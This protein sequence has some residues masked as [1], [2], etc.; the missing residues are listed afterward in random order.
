MRLRTGILALALWACLP[1]TVSAENLNGKSNIRIVADL[2]NK[3][4]ETLPS[5]INAEDNTNAI[6][7]RLECYGQN[8]GYWQRIRVCNNAYVK[9]I[10][11]VARS[12]IHSRP[13]IGEFVLNVSMCP[14]LF[15][16]CMGQTDQDRE[17]CILFEHQ[18][19]D[20]TLDTYWRGSVQYIQQ[21]TGLGW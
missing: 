17:R 18:C 3:V 11:E 19:I 20:Y 10:V 15:N 13:D 16:L 4:R 7:D 2:Y 6:R 8:H 21:D 5:E 14:I 1:L 9:H 12:T